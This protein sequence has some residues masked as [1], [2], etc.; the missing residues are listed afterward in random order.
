MPGLHL[1]EAQVQRLCTADAPTAVSALRALVSA[2]FL[3][4]THDRAYVRTDIFSERT[5]PRWRPI[6]CLVE[7]A[8][9][10]QDALTA[11]SMAALRYATTLAVTNRARI[12]ALHVVPRPP[13]QTTSLDDLTQQLG[14]SVSAERLR[15]LIDVRA[16]AGSPNEELVRVARN[17]G[18]GLIV[19]AGASPARDRKSVV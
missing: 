13:R 14:R 5:H 4:V 7:L 18:A 16:A 9:D 11:A 10:G 17:I 1:T 15:D 12:T 8:N 3:S 6:L 2:G 19:L